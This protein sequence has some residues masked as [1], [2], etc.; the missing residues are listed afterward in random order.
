VE[1]DNT[2]YTRVSE[3]LRHKDRCISPWDYERMVLE[4]FPA[5]HKVKCIPHAAFIPAKNSYC[6]YA[7]GNVVIVVVPDLRNKNAVDPLRPRLD[8][9][10][11]SLITDFVND[12]SGMQVNVKV[13]NPEYQK[14]QL[15]FSVKFYKGFEF[16]YY[17]NKLIE[18]IKEYLTPWAFESGVDA[19]FGGK[20]Y[21][22]ALVDFVEEQEYVDYVTDFRLTTLEAGSTVYTNAEEVVPS[23]PD[24]IF[25]SDDTHLIYEIK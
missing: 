25:V 16:N 13:K 10:T 14:I 21:K 11:L 24:S 23:T 7:P 15:R 5:V 8:S 3:R 19:E 4:E 18:A 2:F 22:S 12:H 9:N 17:S 20:V 6:W 1:N